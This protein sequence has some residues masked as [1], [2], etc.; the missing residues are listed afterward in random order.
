MPKRKPSQ[1]SSNF[2]AHAHLLSEQDRTA[3][4]VFLRYDQA[5]LR[6]AEYPGYRKLDSPPGAPLLLQ[7]NPDYIELAKD[8]YQAV[9][10]VELAL[11]LYL[12]GAQHI[13]NVPRPADYRD[14]FR[15]IGRIALELL[16]AVTNLTDY[17]RE[18]IALN[19]QDIHAIERALAGLG[20]ASAAIVNNMAGKSSKGAPKNAALYE[21]IRRLRRTF[22]DY[23]QGER[24]KRTNRGAFQIRAPW[25][26]DE[27]DFIEHALSAA[28]IVRKPFRGL[29]RLLRDARCSLVEDRPATV[30]RIARK[31]AVQHLQRKRKER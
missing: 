26:K 14:T 5:V 30:S 17:Y 29:P 25:E 15:P 22:R 12:E 6:D 27:S 3:L 9:R 13:D 20:G 11:G 16:S 18:Q 1:A 7:K 31:L 19:G 28:R 2:F 10:D 4:L 8:P 21:V 23:Y 24:R